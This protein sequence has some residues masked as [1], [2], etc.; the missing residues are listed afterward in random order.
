MKLVCLELSFD[1]AGRSAADNLARPNYCAIE[2]HFSIGDRTIRG[3]KQISIRA[4]SLYISLSLYA[5]MYIYFRL[6]EFR[7]PFD[8]D[9]IYKK[10]IYKTP[11]L[12]VAPLRWSKHARC[13]LGTRVEQ[14]SVFRG[15]NLNISRPM[16]RHPRALQ[17]SENSFRSVSAFAGREI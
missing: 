13:V 6:S 15:R 3:E 9:T 10:W 7:G 17:P 2:I 5:R 1:A 14:R 8:P 4:L 11:H 16:A 12:T